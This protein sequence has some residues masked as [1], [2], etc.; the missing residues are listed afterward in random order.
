MGSVCKWHLL[1]LLYRWIGR[2]RKGAVPVDDILCCHGDGGWG[3]VQFITFL[4][5]DKGG[6]GGYIRNQGYFV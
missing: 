5:G 1:Y 3:L 2:E 6:G 4:T